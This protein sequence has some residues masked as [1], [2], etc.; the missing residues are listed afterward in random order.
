MLAIA[1]HLYGGTEQIDI[2]AIAGAGAVGPRERPSTIGIVSRS[3]SP[4][5]VSRSS[6]V[7][8]DLSQQAAT[9]LSQQIATITRTTGVEADDG[10]VDGPPVLVDSNSDDEQ[11]PM[12]R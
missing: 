11:S 8:T 2:A 1:E 4:V 7:S 5:F 10:Y 3:R 12:D 6:P 9:D